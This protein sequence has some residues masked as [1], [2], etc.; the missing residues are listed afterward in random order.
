MAIKKNL[1]AKKIYESYLQKGKYEVKNNK[2]KI[3]EIH[4]PVINPH[5]EITIKVSDILKAMPREASRDRGFNSEF[6]DLLL[7]QLINE[8]DEEQAHI[9]AESSLNS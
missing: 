3:E 8:V 2:G 6:Y 7:R 5:C 9:D 4:T 1:L